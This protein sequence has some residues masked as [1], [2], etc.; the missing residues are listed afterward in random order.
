MTFVFEEEL[1]VDEEEE[2]KRVELRKNA[3]GHY[4]ELLI[5]WYNLGF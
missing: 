4:N 2:P 1:M 3:K 5:S